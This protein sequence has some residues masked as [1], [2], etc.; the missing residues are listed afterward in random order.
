MKSFSF[1]KWDLFKL[2]IVSLVFALTMN[3]PIYGAPLSG[4]RVLIENFERA[5]AT[6]VWT[7]YSDGGTG[8]FSVTSNASRPGKF[9]QL[10]YNMS[11]GGSYVQATCSPKAAIWAGGLS[12]W[13]KTS[14]GVTLTVRVVDSQNQTLQYAIPRP[15]YSTNDSEW[16]LQSVRFDAQVN[17]YWGGPANGRINGTIKS[18]AI[19]ALPLKRAYGSVSNIISVPQSS[20]FIDDITLEDIPAP[21]NGATIDSF[22]TY[23][24]SLAPWTFIAGD[25]TPAAGSVASS[26]SGYTGRGA[27]ISYDLRSQGNYVAAS[28]TL[29]SVLNSKVI[30]FW[31]KSDLN[32]RVA[33]RVSDANNEYFQYQP[34]RPAEVV[35]PGEWYRLTVY[36]DSPVLHWGGDMNGRIDGGVKTLQILVDPPAGAFGTAYFDEIVSFS[37]LV[38]TSDSLVDDFSAGL[39]GTSPSGWSFYGGD[40]SPAQGSLKLVSG[41]A[42]QGLVARLHFDLGSGGNYVAANKSFTVPVSASLVEL[43]FRVPDS[44]SPRLRVTD[45]SGQTF[46]AV[47]PTPVAT[48]AWTHAQVELD[49]ISFFW[50]GS[51]DG[52]F[53]GGVK[54]ISVLADPLTGSAVSGDLDFDNVELRESIVRRLN[55]LTT[56]STIPV[57]T[58][59]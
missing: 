49:K 32:A 1:E 27:Q 59:R 30:S 16:Y 3:F 17:S 12:F 38:S 37:N 26:P 56:A 23:T 22:E 34:P 44:V 33:I 21:E 15:L 10:S 28:Y 46:Q 39:I 57:S 8:F 48:G 47:L 14:A 19:L 25:P 58:L 31:A 13:A 54:S 55:P 29:P 51:N 4:T 24:T 11:G 50:G 20:I 43:D 36:L 18:F 45:S 41:T 5:N 9:G 35:S 7:F 40:P 42:S 2:A 6:N 53:H 52:I